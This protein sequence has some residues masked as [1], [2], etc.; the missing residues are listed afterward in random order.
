MRFISARRYF[1]ALATVLLSVS[2]PGAVSAAQQGLEKKALEGAQWELHALGI[3]DEATRSRL[4]TMACRRPV[5]IAIVGEGGVSE[6]S[7]SS[8]IKAQ[9]A[10]SQ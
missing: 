3:T 4:V 10:T 1:R 2:L 5:T 6:S 8:T 9:P 7:L